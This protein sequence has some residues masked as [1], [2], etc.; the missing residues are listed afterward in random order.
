VDTKNVDTRRP[1]NKSLMPDGL[2]KDLK[3]GD[4]ADLYSYLQTLKV[5][6]VGTSPPR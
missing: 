3:P 6:N 2:L 5:E 4:L 1:S